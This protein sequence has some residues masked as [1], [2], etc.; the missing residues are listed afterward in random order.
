MPGNTHAPLFVCLRAR[1]FPAFTLVPPPPHDTPFPPADFSRA[2]G[3]LL[4]SIATFTASELFPY[5]TFTFF[6]VATGLATLPRPVLK[7][8]VIDSPDVLSAIGD[9]PRLA[10][11]L[12]SFYE[13][14]YTAFF[15]A[16][17]AV[18]PALLRDRY[19]S[20]HAPYFLREMRIAAYGQFLESYK[21]VTAAGMAAAFGVTPAFLDKELSRFIAAGRINAKLD[22]VE[23]ACGVCMCVYVCYACAVSCGASNPPHLSVAPHPPGVIETT[24]P[25]TKNAQYASVIKQGDALLNKIQKLSRV[26][27]M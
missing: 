3:L 22:A 1:T 15:A 19:L 24:R 27:A 4:D 12:N 9:V 23:G 20:R 17:T 2:G 10:D 7:K 16:L 6:T 21:S 25:D 11:L 18:Y 13:G 14:R 26:V 8:K 5:S